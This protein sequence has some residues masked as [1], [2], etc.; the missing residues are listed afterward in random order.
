M[1]ID[2]R[3]EELTKELE[4]LKKL[5]DGSD[6]FKLP[7]FGEGVYVVLANGQ[8]EDT[9]E[10]NKENSWMVGAWNQGNVFSDLESATFE[11]ER[12]EVIHNLR[13][14]AEPI[15]VDWVED[16]P[17]H[18]F[19]SYSPYL[20]FQIEST[21]NMRTAGTIYYDSIEHAKA[22]LAFVGEDKIKKYLL[23]VKN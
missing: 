18:W 23:G 10:W 1:N 9:L 13:L 20:G 3:I 7:E 16:G 19:F 22:A 8:V 5:K 12:R 2:E 11:S 6:V 4:I 15:S 21:N 17:K 14:L